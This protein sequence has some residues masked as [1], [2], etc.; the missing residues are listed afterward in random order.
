[1]DSV[2]SRLPQLAA[3]SREAARGKFTR[4]FFTGSGRKRKSSYCGSAI[5]HRFRISS[6]SLDKGDD[7]EE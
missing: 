7:H 2:E 5:I 4:G 6:G 3:S 1:M